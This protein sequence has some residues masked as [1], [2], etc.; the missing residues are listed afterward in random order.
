ME[1]AILSLFLIARIAASLGWIGLASEFLD[2]RFVQEPAVERGDLGLIVG[3]RGGARPITFDQLAH[4]RFG[5]VAQHREAAV[6]R[7]VG[8]DRRVLGPGAV[9]IAEEIV[10]GLDALVHA[11]GVDTPGAHAIGLG[12]LGGAAALGGLIEQRKH[13]ALLVDAG[14]IVGSES[15]GGRGEREQGHGQAKRLHRHPLMCLMEA[16]HRPL[17]ES[18]LRSSA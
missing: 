13:R 6:G 5:K 14:M 10:A 3:R 7:A 8:G 12:G 16:I 11:R 18:A 9:H 17:P 2:R 4:A 1:R 15:R